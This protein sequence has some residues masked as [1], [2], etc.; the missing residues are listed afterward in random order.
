MIPTLLRLGFA[1]GFLPKPPWRLAA[2]AAAALMWSALPAG[3]ETIATT[4]AA[5]IVGA[6]VLAAATAAAGMVLG[7]KLAG[8]IRAWRRPRTVHGRVATPGSTRNRTPS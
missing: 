6:L 4:D 5:R 7:G 3:T 8:V 2:L 1:I